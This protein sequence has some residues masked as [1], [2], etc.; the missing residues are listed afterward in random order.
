MVG[1]VRSTPA[2]TCIGVVRILDYHNNTVQHN[3]M[4]DQQKAP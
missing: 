3:V 2:Q 1:R 4:S